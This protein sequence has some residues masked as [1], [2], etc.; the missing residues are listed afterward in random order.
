MQVVIVVIFLS[1]LSLRRATNSGTQ[2]DPAKS[3]SIHA[4]LAESDGENQANQS[5]HCISIH[6]LLA[7]SDNQPGKTNKHAGLFLSTLSL[8][9]ATLA[10]SALLEV[11]PLFLSTLSL[12]RAT[13]G[14]MRDAENL[15][16]SIHALLAESDNGRMRDAENLTISIHALLAESDNQPGK[17]NKHAG[18]FLSTL[19]LR[20][21]TGRF[22]PAGSYSVISI[23]ALLAESDSVWA[24]L[25]GSAF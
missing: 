5:A 2:A 8:R 20:R 15:T 12:R 4:L 10:V 6:A 11:V 13:N 1:T 23:H 9:R 16:I 17:T 22:G 3:I 18:L 25:V 14:R 7:E 19:S 21:A 24:C